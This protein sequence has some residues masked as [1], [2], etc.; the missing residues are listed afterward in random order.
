MTQ[1]THA[2]IQAAKAKDLAA[3][4]AVIAET[5]DLLTARARRLAST[6]GHTDTDLI[7]DLAQA[8]RIAVWQAIADFDGDSPAQFMAFVDR[9][10]TRA[11]AD[12]RREATRPGV[13]P[14]TAK[15]FE[16]ALCLA[17]GDPYKAEL[18]AVTGVRRNDRMSPELAYSARLSWMGV[19]SL[20]RPFNVTTLGENVTLGDVVARD[21]ELPPDLV[22]SRDV[23]THRR[24]VIRNQVHRT[25]GLLSERQR[26]VLKAAEGVSPVDQYREGTDDD[27]LAADMRVTPYQVQQ[28]RTKGKT[29]FRELY[30]AGAQQW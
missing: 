12:A 5:D 21:I 1:L 22:E 2:Q 20:D 23:E 9:K 7:E 17:A 29:R 3:I 19:D 28:A 8:G 26:H 11:M 4:T 13:D 16:D 24:K 18:L 25:L 6:G 30:T 15:V 27:L 10:I 14:H